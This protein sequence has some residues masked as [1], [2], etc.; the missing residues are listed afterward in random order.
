M[1]TYDGTIL[2]TGGAVFNVRSS[3]YGAVGNGVNDDTA[4]IQ[5]AINAAAAVPRG[6]VLIP[7]GTYVVSALTVPAG[8]TI[9]GYGAVLFRPASQPQWTQT[10]STSYSGSA[11]SAPLVIRGL[12]IDGNSANQGAYQSYQL[13]HSHLIFLQ[14]DHNYAGRLRVI[15]EDLVLRN[16]VADGISVYRNVDAQV[17][18]CRVENCWRSGL[19]VT[20]GYTKLQVQNL[21][22]TGAVDRTGIDVEVDGPGYG[23]VKTVELMFDGMWL[24]ADFDLALEEGSK[25][26]ATNLDLLQAPFHLYAPTSTVRVANSRFRVASYYE[27]QNSIQLPHDVTFANCIFEVADAT[28]SGARHSAGSACGSSTAT[29]AWPPAWGAGTRWP[30]STPRATTATSTTS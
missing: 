14:G 25:L 8:I 24:D 15:L 18:N 7:P 3:T 26:I 6:V 27:G 19:A 21:V 20:G 23:N 2:D 12:T 1:P 22:T 28:E 17:L 13:E 10:I 16:C 11:D 29:S 30:R 4:E 9:E 5:A